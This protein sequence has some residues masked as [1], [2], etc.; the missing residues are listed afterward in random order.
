M[1]TINE[2]ELLEAPDVS[3]WLKEQI[4]TS[5]GKD[6]V[7]AYNDALLLAE[8]LQA[9]VDNTLKNLGCLPKV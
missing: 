8:V 9:R 1:A 3:Y 4:R 5:Y 2:K 6:V 7:D